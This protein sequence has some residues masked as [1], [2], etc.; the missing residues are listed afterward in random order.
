MKHN[1]H[2]NPPFYIGQKV[3]LT[4][5]SSI[6]PKGTILTVYD[7]FRCKCGSWN[8]LISEYYSPEE[9]FS[10]NCYDCN[11]NN[12]HITAPNLS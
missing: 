6:I 12:I 4:K 7:M 3:V 5:D 1:A 8:I 11:N 2:N 10:R 9:Y